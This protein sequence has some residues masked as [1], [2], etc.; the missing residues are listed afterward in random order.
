LVL[1]TDTL[2]GVETPVT[3]PPPLLEEEPPLQP[4]REAAKKAMPSINVMYFEIRI[5]IA[6]R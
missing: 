1:T 5:M 6:S 4:C 2:E 3:A